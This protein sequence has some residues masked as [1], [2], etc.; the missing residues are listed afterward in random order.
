MT[1]AEFLA[2]KATF[3]WRMVSVGR[4]QLKVIDRDGMEVDLISMGQFLEQVTTKI[5]RQAP[6][7]TQQE[8]T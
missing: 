5:A 2:L 4:G 1:E 6:Q 7:P 8:P 3:P